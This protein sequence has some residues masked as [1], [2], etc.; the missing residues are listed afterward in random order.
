MHR[1]IVATPTF[2]E[3]GKMT[4]LEATVGAASYNFAFDTSGSPLH[5]FGRVVS[6]GART[7]RRAVGAGWNTP[8]G[9]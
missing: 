8:A 3:N 7:A 2:D 4:A 9:C 5:Y 1:D 6:D